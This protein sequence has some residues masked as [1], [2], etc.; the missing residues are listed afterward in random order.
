M[1]EIGDIPLC[2]VEE[3]QTLDSF[4]YLLFIILLLGGYLISM[5]FHQL[6][7]TF[8]HESTCFIIIGGITGCIAFFLESERLENAV[9]FDSEYFFLFLLP[10]II[11]ESGFTMNKQYF[12]GNFVAIIIFTIGGTI[13]SA[14]VVGIGLYLI[15]FIFPHL[16]NAELF[17]M[18]C[19][20]C[21]F[22]L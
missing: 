20:V 18:E 11:F 8:I 15:S 3:D 14:G 22:Y 7:L 19:I 10:P 12:F 2:Q 5:L 16:F 1:E 17:F 4:V 6:K 9:A 21:N 13:I